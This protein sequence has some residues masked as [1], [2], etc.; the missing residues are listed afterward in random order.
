MNIFLKNGSLIQAEYLK[1]ADQLSA[2]EIE[3]FKALARDRYGDRV[4]NHDLVELIGLG[5]AIDRE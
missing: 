2:R 1:D 3:R 4:C 5:M